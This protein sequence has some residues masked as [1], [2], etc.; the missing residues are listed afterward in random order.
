MADTLKLT[1]YKVKLKD[2]AAHTVEAKS[3]KDA[4][5]LYKKWAGV[6]DT[7]HKFEVTPVK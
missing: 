7:V 3:P 5:E 6:L 4:I 2:C 1:K